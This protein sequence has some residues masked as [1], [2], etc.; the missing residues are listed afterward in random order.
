MNKKNFLILMAVSL[1]MAGISVNAQQTVARMNQYDIYEKH[2]E[3]AKYIVLETKEDGSFVVE[4]LGEWLE[5]QEFCEIEKEID[6][7]IEVRNYSIDLQKAEEAGFLGFDALVQEGDMIR[8]DEGGE[9]VVIAQGENLGEFT[10]EYL[11][12]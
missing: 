5:Q 9:E 2:G 6:E 8:S 7:G 1:S 10:T 11:E 4:A 3:N 12:S